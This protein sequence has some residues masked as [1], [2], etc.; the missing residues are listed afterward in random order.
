MLYKRELRGYTTNAT[1]SNFWRGILCLLIIPARTALPNSFECGIEP[2]SA[3]TPH[4]PC[5]LLCTI[6]IGSGGVWAY[7]NITLTILLPTQL[8]EWGVSQWGG[9]AV[10]QILAQPLIWYWPT[11]IYMSIYDKYIDPLRYAT[12]M[13][14]DKLQN[15]AITWY[16]VARL[17][18]R[19]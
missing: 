6:Y 8:T 4:L 11:L 15:M 3:A 13:H 18:Q 7:P 12:Y 14:T 10:A 2:P 5:N 9:D 16:V 19:G 1:W 17:V